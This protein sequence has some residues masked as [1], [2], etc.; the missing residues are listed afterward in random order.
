MLRCK[1]HAEIREFFVCVVIR[2]SLVWNVFQGN[3]Y[4]YHFSTSFRELIT[5]G[6]LL[7]RGLK[8]YLPKACPERDVLGLSELQ[9]WSQALAGPSFSGHVVCLPEPRGPVSVTQLGQR[10]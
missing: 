10:L 3:T 9:P 8:E 6:Q 7:K 5:L 4:L 1:L 2:I